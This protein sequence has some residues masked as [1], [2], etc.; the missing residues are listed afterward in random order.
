MCGKEQWNRWGRLRGTNKIKRYKLYQ[1]PVIKIMSDG[2]IMF[3]TGNPGDNIVITL[4][5]DRY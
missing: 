5:D 4:Y 1:L 2:N 3:N